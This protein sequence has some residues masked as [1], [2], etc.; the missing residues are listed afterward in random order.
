MLSISGLE[1]LGALVVSNND[2]SPTSINIKFDSELLDI[3]IQNREMS[4]S[5]KLTF[6][7]AKVLKGL[8][9]QYLEFYIQ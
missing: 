3:E 1:G 5:I 4:Q 8:I 6:P 2:T 7:E 9:D